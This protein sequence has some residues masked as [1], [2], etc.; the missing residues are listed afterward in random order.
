M[1]VPIPVYLGDSHQTEVGGQLACAVGNQLRHTPPVVNIG[2]VPHHKPTGC[3]QP[4]TLRGHESQ[5]LYVAVVIA[6]ILLIPG[7]RV[8]GMVCCRHIGRRRQNQVDA[9][10]SSV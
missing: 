1:W 6:S 9:R 3:K 7:E 2:N 10:L 8:S 4:G 5:I